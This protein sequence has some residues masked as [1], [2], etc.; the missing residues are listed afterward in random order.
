MEKRHCLEGKKKKKKNQ[1][2][3]GSKGSVQI[4]LLDLSVE[5]SLLNTCRWKPLPPCLWRWKLMSMAAIHQTQ[6]SS[7]LLARER[8]S[9]GVVSLVGVRSKCRV[10]MQK[11]RYLERCNEILNIL[12]EIFK[13]NR[14]MAP[15]RAGFR[16]KFVHEGNFLKS[17]QIH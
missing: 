13:V 11:K 8:S 5:K 15:R 17:A 7:Y 10:Q 9:L 14:I 3:S 12:L 2:A 4:W 1:I 16:L 6:Y